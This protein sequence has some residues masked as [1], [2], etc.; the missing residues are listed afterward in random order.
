MIRS[1]SGVVAERMETLRTYRYA[2][3]FGATRWCGLIPSMHIRRAVYR[4][5]FH[6]QI[7]ATAVIWGGAEIRDPDR[8]TVG[9]HSVVGH[10]AILDG[11]CGIQIGANV[12]LSAGVWIWTCQHDV[13]SSNFALDCGPVVIED[14][15]W[16]SCR[17]VILPNTT[18]GR[19]AVVAAGAVVTKDVPPF[20]IVG[21]VPA[22]VIGQRVQE[23]SYHPADWYLPF[24]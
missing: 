11:R 18:I 9:E 6:M 13:Q 4:R 22:K 24:Y 12:N 17:T 5:F 10:A 2:L 20:A 19:G 15:A 23:L 14:Y 1:T 7:A 21:G 3:R 8:I 16:V